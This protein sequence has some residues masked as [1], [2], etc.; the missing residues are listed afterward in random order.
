MKEGYTKIGNKYYKDED[1]QS[2]FDSRI[3][4]YTE[5]ELEEE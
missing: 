1:V 2:I 3:Q 5:E 4:S